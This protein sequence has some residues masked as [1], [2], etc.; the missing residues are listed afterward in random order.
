[1]KWL[2]VKSSFAEA[3][4]DRPVESASG[5]QVCGG[6]GFLHKKQGGWGH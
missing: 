5:G 4:E 6:E 1:M 2:A 3:T